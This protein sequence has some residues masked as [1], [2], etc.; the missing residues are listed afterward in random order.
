MKFFILLLL[1]ITIISAAPPPPPP[2]PPA[3]SQYDGRS[4]GAMPCY[5]GCWAP[6]ERINCLNGGYCIQ[7]ATAT[8][9]AYC[10]CPAQYTGF[11]CEQAVSTEPCLNFQCNHGT[12]QKDRNNQPYCSCYEGYGGSRCETQ[13][14]P[15]ARVNCNHGRCEV[16]RATAVCRCFQGY[17]GHDCLTPLGK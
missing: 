3:S 2:P 16:D 7:P 13:I 5:L 9:L 10:H 8:T 17:T 11:R 1:I 6:C 4:V 15:C 12:C 14:D